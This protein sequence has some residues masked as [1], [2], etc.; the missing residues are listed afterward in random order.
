MDVHALIELVSSNE[1][2]F[3]FI[4]QLTQLLNQSYY[5]Q[6]QKDQW[7]HY[8]DVGLTQGI[9]HGRVSKKMGA[10]NSMS[11]TYGRSKTLIQQRKQKYERQ[12]QHIQN[13]MNQFLSK[14]PL[15]LN[16]MNA[17]I[18]LIENLIHKDQYQLRIE[19]EHRRTILHL[20][21]KEH[22]LVHDFY[23]SKPRKSEVCSLVLGEQ[24]RIHSFRSIQQK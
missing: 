14:A 1:D 8:N 11:Y 4:R 10:V 18:T 24:H 12:F 17:I 22:Q 6:L 7:T 13:E 16:D 21:A 20:D 9:W 23:Q 15:Q 5:F 3:L 2:V 19:L